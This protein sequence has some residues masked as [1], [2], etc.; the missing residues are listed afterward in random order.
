MSGSEKKTVN[1]PHNWIAFAKSHNKQQKCFLKH[2]PFPF[3][4]EQLVGK[5]NR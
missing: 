3:I 5:G 2:I 1:L 4:S